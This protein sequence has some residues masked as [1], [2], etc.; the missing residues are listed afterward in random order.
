MAEIDFWRERT[1]VLSNVNDQLKLPVVKK[2]MD[3]MIRAES[4]TVQELE[5]TTAE[6]IK[7]YEE[8]VNN[9]QFLST[10]ERQFK[11]RRIHIHLHCSSTSRIEKSIL[12]IHA[13]NV[14]FVHTVCVSYVLCYCTIYLQN[15]ATGVDFKVVLN[16]IPEMMNGLRMIWIISR[17]YNTDERMES[18]MESIAWELSE[19]VARVVNIR[20]LFK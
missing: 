17:H 10:L 5:K 15:L 8:S 3:V 1:A 6:L 4:F 16:T 7:Y 12:K 13:Y 2:I 11:V 14:S 9:V 18:L 20:V 19:R